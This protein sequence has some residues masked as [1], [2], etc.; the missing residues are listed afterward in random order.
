MI[1]VRNDIEIPTE[2]TLPTPSP[3]WHSRRLRTA[4]ENAPSEA[5]KNWLWW[6]LPSPAKRNKSF[7]DVIE[8]DPADVEWHTPTQ[9]RQLLA[10]MS[11][12]NR[13]K[14]EAAKSA[15][16]RLIKDTTP[17]LTVRRLLHAEGFRY[18]LHRKDLPGTPDL[19][20]DSRRKVVFVHGC[21]WHG[22]ACSRGN[23]QPKSN[24]DYWITK[25]ARNRARDATAIASLEASGWSVFTVWECET[26][27]PASVLPR[28]LHFLRGSPAAHGLSEADKAKLKKIAPQRLK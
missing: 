23:R 13:A 12:V 19:V 4:F 2:M 27:D 26:K 14:L 24:A 25:V 1:G 17:E 11:D 5:R 15:K 21:F 16:R 6:S 18:R 10:M 28:L 9:T 3:L 22:H 8:D 7:A 20:F